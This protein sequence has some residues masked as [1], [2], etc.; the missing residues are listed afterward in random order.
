MSQ[1]HK[2]IQI[3]PP[4]SKPQNRSP[5]IRSFGNIMA[6]G[7]DF[8][9]LFRGFGMPLS[10]SLLE[11]GLGLLAVHLGTMTFGVASSKLPLRLAD[12]KHHVKKKHIQHNIISRLVPFVHHY[13]LLIFTYDMIQNSCDCSVSKYHHFAFLEAG[14]Q[15]HPILRVAQLDQLPPKFHLGF[16]GGTRFPNDFSE[17]THTHTI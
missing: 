10:C 14:N 7:T 1:C 17:T 6:T 2:F 9:Q 8:S 4:T 13:T 5:N 12:W 16:S 15:L 3:S 11:Q